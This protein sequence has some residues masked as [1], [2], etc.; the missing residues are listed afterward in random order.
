[1]HLDMVLEASVEIVVDGWRV[2]TN[3]RV[4]ENIKPERTL[5]SMVAQAALIYFGH[6]VREERRGEN[7]VMLGR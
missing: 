4:L 7:G 2:K 3:V 6:V 5:E 1:M